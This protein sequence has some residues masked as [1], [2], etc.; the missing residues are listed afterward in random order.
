[1]MQGDGCYLAFAVKNNAGSP[2]APADI[3]DM[4]ISLAHLRKTLGRGELIY[5]DGLWLFPLSQSETFSLWPAP[6]RCQIRIL[7]NNGVVEGKALQ[8]LD[9]RES[10]SKEVL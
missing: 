5:Q 4:E 9:I 10:I 3:Q 7:W 6:V 2:V 1:M 8:G